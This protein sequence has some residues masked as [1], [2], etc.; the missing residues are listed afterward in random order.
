MVMCFGSVSLFLYLCILYFVFAITFL[1]LFK[2]FALYV[3]KKIGFFFVLFHSFLYLRQLLLVAFF[4]FFKSIALLA[5]YYYYFEYCVCVLLFVLC[6][7]SFLL[8]FFCNIWNYYIPIMIR[9]CTPFCITHCSL[10]F[11]FLKKNLYKFL[12][13]N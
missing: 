13:K 2:Y 7:F 4:F 3:H 9:T 8:L 10:N 11:Y 12:Y 1:S 6:F 5:L